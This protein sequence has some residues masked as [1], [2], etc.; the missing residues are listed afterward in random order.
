[1][2]NQLLLNQLMEAVGFQVKVANNGKEGVQLF[3]NWHPHLIWMDRRMPVMDGLEATRRIRALDGGKDVKIAAVT[4]SAFADQR[5]E[6][7]D[8]G[9][10]DFVRK[11]Y[12]ANEIYECLS[13]HLGVKYI[14]EGVFKAEEPT[15]TLTPDMLAKL[16]EAQRNELKEALESLENERIALVIKQ[17]AAYDQQLQKT[18]LQLVDNFDYPAILKALYE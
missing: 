8:A 5:Q 1:M 11:P 9:M 15:K 6:M 2:E 10:D 3:Q 17:I 13:K 7:M 14:Y 18:L 12:R 4:A 16:P